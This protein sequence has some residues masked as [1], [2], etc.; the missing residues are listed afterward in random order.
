MLVANDFSK[1]AEHA[2]EY[3]LVFA[4]KFHS[5]IHLIW[6]DNTLSDEIVIDTIDRDLRKEIKSYSDVLIQKYQPQLETGK[7]EI[8]FRK[9]KVYQEI[10]KAARQIKAD[11]I[12]AGTHGVSG[13]EQYWIGSNSYR[14]VTQAPCPVV[15][16]RSDYPINDTIHNILLPLDSSLETKQKLPYTCEIAMN[17]GATI[18]ML[19]IYNTPLNVIR[20]RID[21]IAKEAEKC[22]ISKKVKYVVEYIEAKNVAVSI[23]DYSEKNKID[24]ITIM[25]DQGTT[26]ANKFLGPY[27]QQLI[28]NS[29]VPV[30]SVRA[31]E[32]I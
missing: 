15:T 6:V 3:A 20:K 32:Y 8:L 1:N 2:L 27:S 18:H 11:I 10:T 30:M 7:I 9:G 23:L 21:S 16:I 12:F 29:S 22:M 25:T 4:K 17:F 24:L 28:N 19:A 31:K 14:I 26:T 5:G 13:Y